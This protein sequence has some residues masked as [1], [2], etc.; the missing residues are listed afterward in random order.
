MLIITK[1][2]LK[3]T[4]YLNILKYWQLIKYT[5]YYLNILKC[6]NNYLNIRKITCWNPNEYTYSPP[7]SMSIAPPNQ[8]TW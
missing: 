6:T 2:V 8:Y 7:I 1:K 3:D 4:N 5:N